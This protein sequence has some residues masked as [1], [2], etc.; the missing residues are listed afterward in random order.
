MEVHYGIRS[1]TK[2][3]NPVV[4]VGTF[5][6]V[7]LGHQKILNKLEKIAEK[8]DGETVLL[9]FEP[10]PRKVLFKNQ[11][12][13]LINTLE[14]KINL[15]DTYGLDHLVIYPFTQEF[16]NLSARSY[17][18]ELLI[19]KLK[20]HTLV[21]GYDHHFGNDRQGNIELLKKVK[22]DF[23][24]KLAEISA[25]EIDEIKVSSTKIRSAITT[26][27]IALVK[28]YSGKHFHFSGKIVKGEGIGKKL[29][30]PTANI[31]IQDSDKIIPAN[32]VYAIKC[33]INNAQIYG[34]MNI[35]NRPTVDNN[36][37]T[38]IE[39]HLFNWSKDIYGEIMEIEVVDKI[40]NE[41]KFPSLDMLKSQIELD[42]IKAQKVLNEEI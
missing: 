37:T 16:S 34:V 10:H 27:K 12:L 15:L 9:T 5:D 36:E 23:G 22:N 19:K 14:E 38:T 31:K 29:N 28:N 39:C 8:I 25:H 7:H 35:G 11:T 30:H 6:G 40:R 1:F 33:C 26:G 18:E 13:K 21:I 42:C 4:T 2:I 3:K 24:F 32:G 20:T 17:I 41:V